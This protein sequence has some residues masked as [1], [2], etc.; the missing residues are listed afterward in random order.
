M[1][2]MW[3]SGM[4]VVG[5]LIGAIAAW[6]TDAGRVFMK[7]LAVPLVLILTRL[8]W[9]DVYPIKN[10]PLYVF[11]DFLIIAIAALITDYAVGL[12]LGR[13]DRAGYRHDSVGH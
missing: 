7:T 8:V 3:W 5:L 10:A 9:P 6:T 1:I 12:K 2:W 13:N 4:F 11:L